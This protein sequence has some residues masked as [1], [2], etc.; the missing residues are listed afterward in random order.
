MQSKHSVMQSQSSS[1]PISIQLETEVL[2]KNQDK[3]P[4]RSY[5]ETGYRKYQ[6]WLAMTLGSNYSQHL[7]FCSARSLNMIKPHVMGVDLEIRYLL[8]R[9]ENI[10]GPGEM[11]HYRDAIQHTLKENLEL[12]DAHIQS[13]ID[14]YLRNPQSFALTLSNEEFQKR[15][16]NVP[17]AELDQHSFQVWRNSNHSTLNEKPYPITHD[18]ILNGEALSPPSSAHLG[19]QMMELSGLAPVIVKPRKARKFAVTFI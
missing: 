5:L 14:T 4:F 15:L 19:L 10:F 8:K 9:L 17:T 18:D 7:N 11:K 6:T 2:Q 13:V 1:V 16:K 12:S 3:M